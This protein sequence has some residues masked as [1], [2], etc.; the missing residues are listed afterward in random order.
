MKRIECIYFTE[1]KNYETKSLTVIE[2]ELF[3]ELEK[4]NIKI[5]TFT[6]THTTIF[7]NNKNIDF[8]ISALDRHIKYPILARKMF[9]N[10]CIHHILHNINA[11]MLFLKPKDC[12]SIVT[13][14]DIHSALPLKDMEYR[15][16]KGGILRNFFKKI[17][18]KA[19]TRADFIIAVSNNT[20][21]D[22]MRYLKIPE[23]KICVIYNGVNHTIFKPREK[24]M[25]R[26]KLNL[27]I[28]IS[29]VLNVSSDEPRK[30]VETLIEAV[31]SISKDVPNLQLIHV[32]TLSDRCK[33]LINEFKLENTVKNFDSVSEQELAYFYNAADIF[34]FP[35]FYEGFGLPPLEAM[36]SGCPVLA[37]NRSSLP[38]VI[39]N[40]GIMVDPK[41]SKEFAR[42]I[43]KVL[44]DD[45]LRSKMIKKGLEQAATF[46]W[47]K[48]A[49]E[50]IAVYRELMNKSFNE[51]TR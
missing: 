50:T 9:K 23:E 21:K 10:N 15:L 2:R 30:N 24:D 35:S 22:L 7:K 38:E 18:N 13:C 28:N 47:D 26:A 46:S 16:H 20:K 33:K 44:T 11:S 14:H 37:S 12:I 29:I 1:I 3:K 5:K 51:D 48:C 39:G 43:E 49:E 45:D 19:F 8:V 31:H 40:A 25:A 17:S 32:G 42:K 41:D 27:S 6:I 36:A 34:V 4:Y